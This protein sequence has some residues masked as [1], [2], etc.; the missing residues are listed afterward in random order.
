MSNNLKAGLAL[1]AAVCAGGLYAGYRKLGSSGSTKL[2]L[3]LIV[4][5]LKEI[6]FQTFNGCLLF[7]EGVKKNVLSRMPTD[8][9]KRDQIKNKIKEEVLEMYE[10][11]QHLIL[12]KYGVNKEDFEEAVNKQEKE[13]KKLEEEIENLMLDAIAGK[14]PDI[15]VPG[16]VSRA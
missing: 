3:E 5:I 6:K 1:I 2:T 12:L 14:L 9:A 7:S 11:K 15:S 8:E 10:E 13:L 16:E 4:R